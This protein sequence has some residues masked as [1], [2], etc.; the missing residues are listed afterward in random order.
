VAAA[1]RDD[2]EAA[3]AD[4]GKVDNAALCRPQDRAVAWDQ[5]I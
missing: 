1:H 2:I 3:Q 4:N 5:R